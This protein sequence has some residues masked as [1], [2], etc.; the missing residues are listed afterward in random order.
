MILQNS[1]RIGDGNI[2]FAEITECSFSIQK[3]FVGYRFSFSFKIKPFKQEDSN[4]VVLQGLDV[5]LSY[6]D[7]G[8]V[9]LLGRM[10]NDLHDGFR[11]LV[12]YEF[13]LRKYFDIRTDDFLRLIDSSHRGD[14]FF[15]FQILPV[16]RDFT[17]HSK[18]ETGSLKISHSDWLRYIGSAELDRFELITIRIP[19]SSSHL[20]SPFSEA[21]KKIREAEQQY[22][23]GN[24]NGAAG[25]CRAAWR[26]V[27]SSAPAG[28]KPLEHIL[29]SVTGDP[30]RKEFALSLIKGL[31]D[32]QNKAV[33]FEGDVKSGTPPADISAEDA[34]L[35]IHW[36][37]AIIGYLSLL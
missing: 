10:I 31:H 21:L 34:L 5:D 8:S 29:S 9:K 17:Q 16:F 25:S 23:R 19:V 26:T 22:I 3:N 24:W 33:H 28:T 30:R 15:E 32:I 13:S 36:Y 14:M 27:L 35:C 37:S 11:K 2:S 18:S 20:H 7:S 6:Q 12:G 1:I 4:P